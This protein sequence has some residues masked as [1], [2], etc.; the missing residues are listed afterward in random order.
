MPTQHYF[1]NC[2]LGYS[3]FDPYRIYSPK[4]RPDTVVFP[5]AAKASKGPTG[6]SSN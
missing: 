5:A 4:A 2:A 1:Q 3:S 6:S